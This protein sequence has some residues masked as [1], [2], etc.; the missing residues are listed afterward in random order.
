MPAGR[1]SSSSI[2][3][4][5][6][7]LMNANTAIAMIIGE[8]T[9]KVMRSNVVNV[10][11]PATRAAS[12]R[13]APRRRKIGVSSM[14]LNQMPPVPRCTQTMPQK[15]YGLN[16]GPSTKGRLAAAAVFKKPKL[17]SSNRIQASVSGKSGT[18]KASQHRNSTVLPPGISVRAINQAAVAD[19]ASEGRR[20][21]T[22]NRKHIHKALKHSGARNAPHHLP[23]PD[24]SARP[25]GAVVSI[26]HTG[27]S[28]A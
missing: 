1:P 12:S 18:K 27:T 10:L 6:S 9:G 22:E 21:T 24:H 23:P 11:A 19:K 26:P 17:G 20:R 15:L 5:S 3:N 16:N 28:T 8:R 7:P 4:D 13:V 25:A 14:M 2:L